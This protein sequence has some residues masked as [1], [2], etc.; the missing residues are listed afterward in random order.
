MIAQSKF[1][2]IVA[3]VIDKLE[4]GYYHPQ[5]L[6]DG[7]V[8]DMRYANSGE[9]MFGIDRKAGG[10]INTT[11]AGLAFWRV[12]DNANA[13][14]LWKWNFKGGSLYEQLKPLAAA[15]MYPE[16][17]KNTRLYLSPK[18]QSIIAQDDRLLFHFVYATWNGPGWFKK[19][20]NDFNARTQAGIT[21]KNQLVSLAIKSRT[22]EGLTSGSA[23]NSLIKQG[24]E[25]IAA[26]INTLDF[27]SDTTKKS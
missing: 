23:P 24:G 3:V 16:F 14:R 25:K 15:V 12:I 27:S 13:S 2:E 1:S 18:S 4:G 11:P 10:S 20:A 21:D 22:M 26:F 17:L 6:Q 19:F 7:R 5:M 9:T 8:K